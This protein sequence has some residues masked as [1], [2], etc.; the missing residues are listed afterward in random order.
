[1]LSRLSSRIINK[2]NILALTAILGMCS[3]NFMFVNAASAQVS[4]ETQQLLDETDALLI[5]AG[6]FIQVTEQ[7][8]QQEMNALYSACNSGNSNACL[9][10]EIRKKIED[11]AIDN[12]IQRLRNRR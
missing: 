1:M 5:E 11:R 4:S 9:Q 8:R 10:Y 3:S 7:Q 12:H 2:K 6:K